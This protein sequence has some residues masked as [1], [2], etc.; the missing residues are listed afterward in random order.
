MKW[1]KII[2]SIVEMVIPV[3]GLVKKNRVEKEVEILTTGIEQ[4]SKTELSQDKGK[5]LK[6]IVRDLAVSTGIHGRLHKKIE[7]FEER[8]WKKLL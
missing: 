2:I 7:K 4:Y 1:L 5:V 3:W 8:I 6:G